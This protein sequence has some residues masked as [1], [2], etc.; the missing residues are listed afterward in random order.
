MVVVKARHRI[1]V[2]TLVDVV[3]R[4]G[5]IDMR[6]AAPARPVEGIQAHQKIQRQRPD[7]YRAEV[8]VSFEVDTPEVTLVVSGRIDGVMETADGVVVEEIKS[9]RRDLD[10]ISNEPNPCHWGQAKVYAFLFSRQRQ[11]TAAT[12]R[13]TYY[14]LDSDD[15]LELTEFL[16][17]EALEAFFDDLIERY[18]A[19]A[20]MLV[21]WRKIRD[22][23]ILALAFPFS[24]YR[25]G[26][27]TMAVEIYRTIRD[28]GQAII[29]A[30]T[31]IGKTM[32][33]LFPAVKSIAKGHIDR[34]FFLTARNTGKA[35]AIRAL[36]I[37]QDNSLR[38]KRVSLTAKDRICFCPDAACNPEVCDFARGHFDRLADALDDAF[39]ADNLD[40]RTI[41]GVARSHR[42]CPFEFSLE[43]S[44]WADCIICD[45]NYAFDP[46][47]YLRRF[48]D[49]ENGAYA[50][51]VD[52]AHN[53]VDRSRD[54]FSAQ[55]SKT[56]FLALR[57]AVKSQLPAVYRA[58][59]KINTWMRKAHQR[60]VETDGFRA[61]ERLP[62]GLTPLLRV[63]SRLSEQWLAINQPLPFRDAVMDRYFEVRSFL[64]VWDEYD[65]SYVTTST[66]AGP[67]LQ[68]KLF[69]LDPSRQLKVAL[70]RCHAAVFFSATMTPADYFQEILGCDATVSKL[71]IPSPFPPD[72]MKVI[73]AGGVSTY[74]GQ[75]LRSLD[76]LVALIRSCIQVKKGNYLCF[77][78]SYAYM[79]M[80]VAVI[81]KQNW[82]GKLLV[83]AREMG[84]G[85]RSRFLERFSEH[86]PGTLVGFAVMGGIFGEGIDLVGDRLSGAVIVGVGLPAICP[87]RE[88]IRD[89][90]ETRGSGFDYAYR[91]PGINRVLQAGGRVI[92]TDQDRG[93]LVLVDQRF[94]SSD[95]RNLLPMHWAGTTVYSRQ[96]LEKQLKGFWLNQ[97]PQ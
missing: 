56:A 89:H 38:L 71:A 28:G 76:Q 79:Q 8:P 48:F 96:Q 91:Y 74:Y 92:R 68:L 13:L 2:R 42:V 50:F 47:V 10:A 12:V 90:F 26:Q 49:E 84:D 17:Y 37:L 6:F 70:Q 78:P 58:A 3:L 33:A 67:D 24:S 64:R 11:L 30:A 46:R 81:E 23:A 88:L 53:M 22:D 54:M 9:T 35:A 25:S 85:E 18:L 7:G 59:G 52:E 69:C 65:A 97:R 32:A 15:I 95:Y 5:D 62:D 77:F 86:N 1:A 29:Q 4:A 93:V 27:R 83:Q 61:D 66:V 40:R 44:R 73:V 14:Q 80:A 60:A 20:T 41:E 21:R 34:I 82:P 63:F 19:W 75:R 16:K 39:K 51:L 72:N 55:L 57:R 43:L 45:Y 31:G 87:E 36:N 94:C